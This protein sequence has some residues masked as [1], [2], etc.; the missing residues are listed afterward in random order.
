[1]YF[2]CVVWKF[3]EFF[4][5]SL[6]F[7]NQRSLYACTYPIFCCQFLCMLYSFSFSSTCLNGKECKGCKILLL[8][9]G[10][11]DLIFRKR[12][13]LCFIQDWVSIDDISFDRSFLQGSMVDLHNCQIGLII[14]FYW[15]VVVPH[16]KKLLN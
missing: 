7:S 3:L 13:F 12:S 9:Y 4:I 14:F 8:M 2:V 11:G 16:K 15:S 10:Q 6:K 1:M 5:F